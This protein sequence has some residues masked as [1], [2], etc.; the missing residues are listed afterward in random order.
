MQIRELEV[1]INC[2]AKS[3]GKFLEKLAHA[4]VGGIK[5]S[6]GLIN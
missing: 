3:A 2:K 6:F 5:R 1:V 4:S